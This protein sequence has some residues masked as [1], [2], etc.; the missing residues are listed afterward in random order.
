MVEISQPQ[1]YGTPTW[2][3]LGVPDHRAAM[4]FYAAVFGWEFLEGPAEMGYYTMCLVRGKP[5]AALMKNPDP[6]ATEFW[7]NMYFATDDVDGTLKRISD[8]GGR[9]PM[10]AMD[11]TDQGRTA[12]GVDPVGGQFGLWEGRAHIGAQIVNEP[13]TLVW[14]ELL[15]AQPQPAR[16]FYSTV[17]EFRLEPLPDIDYTVLHRADDRA[18]GGIEGDP[19]GSKPL[20]VTY[21]EVADTDATVDRATTAGAT[22]TLTAQDTPFGRIAGLRDPFGADFRIIRSAPPS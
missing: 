5:V 8:A 17:F 10:A 12:I 7:W 15:T 2:V 18:V 22:V 9:I 3:D 16:E 21:F 6:E 14:N 11:I 13:G 20:W 4:E 1:P 19:T